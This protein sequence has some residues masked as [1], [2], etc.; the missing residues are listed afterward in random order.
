MNR[1]T[2][3]RAKKRVRR[4]AFV[5]PLPRTLPSSFAQSSQRFQPAQTQR[6]PPV[7]KR[8][9]RPLGRK[10]SSSVRNQFP[11]LA[12][13]MERLYSSILSIS[14]SVELVR[15]SLMTTLGKGGGRGSSLPGEPP[16]LALL[17]QLTA[18]FG[19]GLMFGSIGTIEKPYYLL[20]ESLRT[21]RLDQAT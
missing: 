17:R 8:A 4:E 7:N 9:R 14:G 12:A 3:V 21:C 15:T 2:L 16:A 19:S 13:N 18:L 20:C 6:S 1:V 11:T 5:G 10:R